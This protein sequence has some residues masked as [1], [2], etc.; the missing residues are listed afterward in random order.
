MNSPC[1]I[2]SLTAMLDDPDDRIGVNLLAQLLLREEELGDLPAQDR[3]SV[4]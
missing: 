1:R 2:S 3:K 4:V